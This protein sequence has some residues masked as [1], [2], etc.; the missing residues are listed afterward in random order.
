MDDDP[1]GVSQPDRQRG[2]EDLVV[3][4]EVVVERGAVAVGDRAQ[5]EAP[6]VEDQLPGGRVDPLD[7]E[8]HRAAESLLVEVD[9]EVERHPAYDG[10]EGAGVGVRVGRQAGHGRNLSAGAPYEDRHNE[11]DRWMRRRGRVAPP[12]VRPVLVRDHGSPGRCLR[13]G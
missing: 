3:L 1:V 2:A 6:G 10:L 8:G 7:V 4:A 5:V 12:G 11:P 9:V 13:R